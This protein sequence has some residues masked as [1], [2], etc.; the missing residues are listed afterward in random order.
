[1][2]IIVFI[3]II[4]TGLNWSAHLY[5]VLNKFLNEDNINDQIKDLQE[6]LDNI[7]NK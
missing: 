3:L 1:M 5:H 2:D 7:Q 6:E 4:E